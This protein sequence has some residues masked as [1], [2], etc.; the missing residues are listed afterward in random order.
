MARLDR[1]QEAEV[2]LLEE[3]KNG[4]DVFWREPRFACDVV[5]TIT[6]ALQSF[7]VMEEL[8]RAMLPSG[9]IFDQAHYETFLAAR[10][11]DERRNLILPEV[12]K[13]L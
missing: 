8:D 7:D 1:S 9:E 10:I 3:S 13:C 11:N 12:P 4:A 6:P 5:R 2:P